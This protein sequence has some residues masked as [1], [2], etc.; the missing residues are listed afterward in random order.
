[1]KPLLLATRNVK[2][3]GELQRILDGELGL[4]EIALMG[5]ADVPPYD[6]VPRPD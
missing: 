2:K 4:G 1:V 6:E 5:L 3:L